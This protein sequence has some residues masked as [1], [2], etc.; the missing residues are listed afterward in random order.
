MPTRAEIT[1]AAMG[2]K[3]DAV[4]HNKGPN[5]TA[6]VRTLSAIVAGFYHR[7][8]ESPRHRQELLSCLAFRTNSPVPERK[9]A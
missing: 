8:P 7:Q 4:M 5:L 2:A 9:E 1:D 3:A 6:T